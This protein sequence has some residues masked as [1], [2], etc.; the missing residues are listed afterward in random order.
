MD[1]QQGLRARTVSEGISCCLS[2]QGLRLSLIAMSHYRSLG[3]SHLSIDLKVLAFEFMKNGVKMSS[4]SVSA[5][6]S[7]QELKSAKVLLRIFYVVDLGHRYCRCAPKTAIA[8]CRSACQFLQN[9]RRFFRERRPGFSRQ[10]LR[11][12]WCY[13][14]ASASSYCPTTTTTTTTSTSTTTTTTADC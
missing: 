14:L 9:R 3:L 1:C 10:Q 7:R 2:F 13:S 5:K 12:I 6:D 8:Q 11:C 4:S